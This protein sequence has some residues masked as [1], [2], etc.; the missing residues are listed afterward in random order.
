[1]RKP[2]S[3]HAFEIQNPPVLSFDRVEFGKKNGQIITAVGRKKMASR[4]RTRFKLLGGFNPVKAP[5]P[6]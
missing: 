5:K 4:N 2:E 3:P 1:M 6:V